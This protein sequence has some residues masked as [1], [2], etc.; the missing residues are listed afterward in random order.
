M[1]TTWEEIETHAMTYIKEDVSLDF[2]LVNRLPV[3]YNRMKAFMLAAI[4][5]FNRPPEEIERLSAYT[6]PVF[7]TAKYTPTAATTGPSTISGLANFEICAVGILGTDAFGDPSYTPLTVESYS[8]STGEITVS[9]SLEAD[10]T[11]TMYFYQSG[12]FNATLTVT[13]KDILAFCIYDVWEHRFDN[14]ALERTSKIR[15][16]TFTTISEASQTNAGTTRQ[17]LVD[18]QMYDMLRAYADNCE[19]RRVVLGQNMFGD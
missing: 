9:E 6:E 8:P 2:D 18:E 3:F 11:V 7:E 5:R 15:D 10:V 19:Y 1:A 17:K 16:S 14:N 13:E 12:F 4:P